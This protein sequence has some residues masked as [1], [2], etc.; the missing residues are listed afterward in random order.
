MVIDKKKNYDR[1]YNLYFAEQTE[2]QQKFVGLTVYL[3]G[4]AAV[5]IY[6]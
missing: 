4:W 6:E 3:K 2:H 5:G 1:S